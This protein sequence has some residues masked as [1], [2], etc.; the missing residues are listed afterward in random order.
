M[1][2]LYSYS[3]FALVWALLVVFAGL[4]VSRSDAT[5]LTIDPLDPSGLTTA[6]GTVTGSL[7]NPTIF[8]FV[9]TLG[10]IPAGG[11]AGSAFFSVTT[12]GGSGDQAL[13][14]ATSS[15]AVSGEQ[16]LTGAFNG[17]TLGDLGAVTH[18]KLL[19]ANS[20]LPLFL[21]M[22]LSLGDPDNIGGA[23]FAGTADL[24]VN[25]IEVTQVPLPGALVL[26]ASGLGVLGLARARRRKAVHAA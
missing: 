12:Q 22:T 10:N 23:T 4:S 11:V 24:S 14:L 5:T 6:S 15:A 21:A 7:A 25:L 3:R 17:F 9:L 18:F 16:T 20:D 2:R 26:F 13:F 1:K 19:V 8:D